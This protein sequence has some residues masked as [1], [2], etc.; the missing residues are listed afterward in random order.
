M[1]M[2]DN[3][4][5][6]AREE[7]RN[8]PDEYRDIMR[9]SSE[10]GYE[11]EGPDPVAEAKAFLAGKSKSGYNPVGGH[12]E[13]DALI[14]SGV[15]RR[16]ANEAENTRQV[17]SGKQ[18]LSLRGMVESLGAVGQGAQAASIVPSPAS[19]PLS[20]GG[21]LATLPEMLMDAFEGGEDAPGMGSGA[22]A[23]LGLAPGISGGVKAGKG[24]AQAVARA[25]QGADLR[26]TFRVG[27]KFQQPASSVP[28]AAR[29]PKA[30]EPFVRQPQAAPAAQAGP[31]ADWLQ[32][33][34]SQGRTIPYTPEGKARMAGTGLPDDGEDAWSL[35]RDIATRR[36]GAA[37]DPFGSVKDFVG[38]PNQARTM[39]LTGEL[40]GLSTL[41]KAS[42]QARAKE[43]FGR[44]FRSE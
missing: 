32:T 35:L 28:S 39:D 7:K 3:A 9:D 12:G 24:V 42:R 14:K 18:P 23:L 13:A 36:E 27:A 2:Y 33:I 20:V 44:V 10:Q 15:A 40:N 41:D 30:W 19:I 25:K 17:L 37:G 26:N 1:P 11:D 29:M 16:K 22:L 4:W 8:R 5:L 31:S 34:K 43:R 21:T 6:R 38:G